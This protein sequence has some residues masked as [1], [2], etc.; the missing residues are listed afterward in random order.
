MKSGMTFFDLTSKTATFD[1]LVVKN[2]LFSGVGSPD[3]GAWIR[4]SDGI[5]SSEFENNYVTKGFSV[6]DWGVDDANK[7]TESTKPMS[8]LFKNVENLDFTITD[9]E[10]DIYTNGIG[11]PYWRK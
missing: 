5:S 7:P 1:N 6:S 11:D 9:T 3:S 8:E 10:S 2:N 4:V